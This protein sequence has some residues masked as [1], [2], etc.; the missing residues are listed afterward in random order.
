VRLLLPIVLLAASLL[1]L[2]P[3]TS[4][5][6]VDVSVQITVAGVAVGGVFWAVSAS[7]SN[8]FAQALLSSFQPLTEG[9]R[10]GAGSRD[11][12][13]GEPKPLLFLPLLVLPLP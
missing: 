5:A 11:R 9:E 10:P 4:A 12:D 8:R 2:W 6:R 1:C 3:S 7:W 13:A